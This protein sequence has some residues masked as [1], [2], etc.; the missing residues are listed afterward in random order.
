MESQRSAWDAATRAQK[1]A[2]SEAVRD[3]RTDHAQ[4]M[5]EVNDKLEAQG[6]EIHGLRRDRDA[7]LQRI[8]AT[9]SRSAVG[10]PR[11]GGELRLGGRDGACQADVGL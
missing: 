3:I 2:L 1:Q 10:P 6:R 11:A 5:Q 4:A 7:F 8:E 9:E